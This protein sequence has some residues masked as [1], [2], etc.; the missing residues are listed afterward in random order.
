MFD[1]L[2]ETY[3]EDYD[4]DYDEGDF[5]SDFEE[6]EFDEA[7]RRRRRRRPR[8]R[9]SRR[10]G[11]RTSGPAWRR[12]RPSSQGSRTADQ[13]KREAEAGRARDK[14]LV[15]EVNTTKEDIGDVESRLRKVNADLVA[16]RQ[17]SLI[18]LILPRSLDIKTQNLTLAPTTGSTNGSPTTNVSLAT[19]T[20]PAGPGV[21]STVSGVSSKLDLIPIVLFM[22]MARNIGKPGKAS[23]GMGDNSM[24]LPLVLLLTQQQQPGTSGQTSS[25]GLDPTMLLLVLML[26]GGGL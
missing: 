20:A 2:L 8:G 21:V 1:E 25:G 22:S 17:I 15:R 19:T 14:Q 11:V 10:R 4:E 16:L 24:M 18:S 13:L 23:G 3:D 6:L 9:R 26:S 5:G 12:P 7:R